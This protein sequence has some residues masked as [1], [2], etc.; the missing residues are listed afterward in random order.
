MSVTQNKEYFCDIFDADTFLEFL[1]AYHRA[2]WEENYWYDIDVEI[3]KTCGVTRIKTDP[4]QEG[5]NRDWVNKFKKYLAYQCCQYAN[6]KS[7]IVFAYDLYVKQYYK[8]TRN[9]STQT[10]VSLDTNKKYYGPKV[11]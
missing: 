9:I 2:K 3:T 11:L 6:M 7:E 1:G 5:Y 10:D 4:N 8:K